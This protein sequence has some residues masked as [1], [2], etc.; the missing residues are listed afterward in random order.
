M[1]QTKI[2]LAQIAEEA[3]TSFVPVWT[4]LTIG[5]ATVIAK[6]TKIGKTVHGFIKV[7]LGS[8]SSI[9]TNPLVTLPIAF[10]S[11]NG[12]VVAGQIR[13]DDAGTANVYGA[14]ELEADGV[15]AQIVSL[16]VQGANV[17]AL[18]VS[19]VS[20]FT[21]AIGDQIQITFTYEAA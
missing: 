2:P 18:A 7:T 8:S 15:K 13:F 21:W 14:L 1:A 4:N 20:P 9:G 16:G 17:A 11:A 12:N 6:Y 5:N 3:W 19:A 10:S